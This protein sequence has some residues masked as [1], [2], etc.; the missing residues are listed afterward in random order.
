M[1]HPSS[2]GVKL[3]GC[4]CRRCRTNDDASAVYEDVGPALALVTTRRDWVHF[5]SPR[6]RWNSAPMAC[7]G[8]VWLFCTISVSKTH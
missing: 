7:K 8:R 4:G 2:S 6:W 3:L 5:S 1:V